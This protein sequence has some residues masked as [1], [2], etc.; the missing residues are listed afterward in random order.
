MTT[1][2]PD[3]WNKASYAP[4]AD[5]SCWLVVRVDV[6]LVSRSLPTVTATSLEATDEPAGPTALI[7]K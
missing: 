5:M 4:F 1:K 2:F 3:V 7:T 6:A